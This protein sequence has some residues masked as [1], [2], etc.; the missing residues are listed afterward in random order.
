MRQNLCSLET[1]C[2]VYTQQKK[3]LLESGRPPSDYENSVYTTWEI[4]VQQIQILSATDPHAEYALELLQTFA[5]LHF[6]GISED[7]FERAKNNTWDIVEASMFIATSTNRLMPSG[8]DPLTLAKTLKILLD[9]SLITVDDSRR[10]SMHPLVHE[11]SGER[12]STTQREHAWESAVSTMAMS[13]HLHMNH[14][15][16]ESKHRLRLLNHIDACL[17]SP[18]GKKF[19]FAGGLRAKERYLI[20]SKFAAVYEE[21]DRRQSAL[22]LYCKTVRSEQLILQIETPRILYT[23]SRIACC[24]GLLRR[25]EEAVQLQEGILKFAQ[26]N[27]RPNELPIRTWEV[28]RELADLYIGWE[29]YDAAFGILVEIVQ[30]CE[31][32][33]GANDE[34]TWSAK[35]SLA[36]CLYRLDRSKEAV[37]IQEGLVQ[38]APTPEHLNCLALSYIDLGQRKKA[39]KLYEQAIVDLRSRY[40]ELHPRTLQCKVTAMSASRWMTSKTGIEGRIKDLEI[41]EVNL[42]ELHYAT[43]TAMSTL[44]EGY[45]QSGYLEKARHVQRRAVDCSIRLYGSDNQRTIVEMK[46]LAR[47]ERAITA[48]KLCYWWIPNRWLKH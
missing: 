42:G 24:L 29:K 20:V 18:E 23:N 12:M 2:D 13:I 9:F 19:M 31:Q 33:F 16:G 7:I 26:Q 25:F 28:S 6:D 22:E 5:F 30:D 27:T 44:A 14:L 17:N 36:H 3:Q 32:A 34:R 40:G 21:A 38:Y 46:D 47:I 35:K 8:W 10:I 45:L 48:R 43:I 39:R 11:W 1:F 4:S 41:T 37:K 15:E